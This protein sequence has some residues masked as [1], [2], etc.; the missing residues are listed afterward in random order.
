MQLPVQYMLALKTQ[1]EL[2]IA[3]SALNYHAHSGVILRTPIVPM[4]N[5]IN[6][7]SRESRDLKLSMAPNSGYSA[8]KYRP[9]RFLVIESP[10]R[11]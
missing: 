1:K 2:P 11:A 9:Y 3:D 6:Q 8:N 4:N 7:L 5:T 10:P